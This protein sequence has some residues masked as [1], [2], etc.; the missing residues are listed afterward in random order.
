LKYITKHSIDCTNET[1]TATLQQAMQA[2]QQQF[3]SASVTSKMKEKIFEGIRKIV[4]TMKCKYFSS[5]KTKKGFAVC[6]QHIIVN[7]STS[8]NNETASYDIMNVKM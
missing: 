5:E 8:N 7:P 4:K 2:F 1:L 3:S 6:G